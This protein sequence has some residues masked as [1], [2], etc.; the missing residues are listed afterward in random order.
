MRNKE[1]GKKREERE[2]LFR[3]SVVREDAEALSHSSLGV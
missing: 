3:V 1:G 2:K